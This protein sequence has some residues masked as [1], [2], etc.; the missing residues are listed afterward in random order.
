MSPSLLTADHG[1]IDVVFPWAI[2]QLR[3]KKQKLDRH[4]DELPRR[5]RPAAA[6]DAD[7]PARHPAQCL[8]LDGKDRLPGAKN[9]VT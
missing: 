5:G 1:G 2:S 6:R 3:Q 8:A 7:Q 4:E 9:G